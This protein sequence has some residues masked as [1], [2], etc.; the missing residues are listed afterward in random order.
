MAEQNCA[1]ED[2]D[3]LVQ[4]GVGIIAE[5]GTYCSSYC[6][7]AGPSTNSKECGCGHEECG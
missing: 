6:A 3:C 4:D 5:D 7:K 1:H 2:C